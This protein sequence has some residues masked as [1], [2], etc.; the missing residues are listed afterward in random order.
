[1]MGMTRR[2]LLAGSL[3]SLALVLV[4]CDGAL[5][6][7]EVREAQALR[8]SLLPGVV[9]VNEGVA[10]GGTSVGR[11]VLESLDELVVPNASLRQERAD[12][13]DLGLKGIGRWE[14]VGPSGSDCVVTVDEIVDPRLW[15]EWVPDGDAVARIAAGEALLVT[16]SVVCGEG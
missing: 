3:L 16:V 12:I 9:A 11:Y 4:A 13:P 6:P 14:V 7:P 5:N 8:R 10:Q 15:D 2:Y 1:M